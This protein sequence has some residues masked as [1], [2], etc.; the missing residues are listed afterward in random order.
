MHLCN[1]HIHSKTSFRYLFMATFR[2]NDC[3]LLRSIHMLSI[4][5][6]FKQSLYTLKRSISYTYVRKCNSLCKINKHML[7]YNLITILRIH[8]IYWY[9]ETCYLKFK[10]WLN[11]VYIL[12]FA[13]R[14]Y[15]I[16]R[17]TLSLWNPESP[18]Y[19]SFN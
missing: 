4:V 7:L 6:I 11:M 14:N 12:Y 16:Y 17:F 19:T 5:V 8:I 1:R 13:L 15:N 2:H 10:T 18:L 9:T 3:K